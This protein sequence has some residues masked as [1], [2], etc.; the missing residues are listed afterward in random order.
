M[1]LTTTNENQKRHFRSITRNPAFPPAHHR[2]PSMSE[3]DVFMEQDEADR[4][5]AE[6]ALAYPT[7]LF[8]F[9]SP[10]V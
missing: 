10:S 4:V 8:V 3:P 9:P 7:P 5:L 2:R 6:L 1:N